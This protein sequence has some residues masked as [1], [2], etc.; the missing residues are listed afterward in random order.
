MYL[1]LTFFFYYEAVIHTIKKTCVLSK[2]KLLDILWLELIKTM[3]FQSS[4]RKVFRPAKSNSLFQYVYNI[5]KL[6]HMKHVS[7]C[8]TDRLQHQTYRIKHMVITP[9]FC[10]IK[11]AFS[12]IMSILA[13]KIAFK[14]NQKSQGTH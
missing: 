9:C 12:G 14:S 4:L 10:C 6:C 13:A 2:L 3:T 7:E 8:M 11:Y 1:I 5:M